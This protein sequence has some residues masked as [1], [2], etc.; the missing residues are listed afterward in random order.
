MKNE[1]KEIG[2]ALGKGEEAEIGENGEVTFKKGHEGHGNSDGHGHNGGNNGN[3]VKPG[4]SHGI[5]RG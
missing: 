4:R 2:E 5:S 1:L 3:H